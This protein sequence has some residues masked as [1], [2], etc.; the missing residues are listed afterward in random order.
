[1]K[2]LDGHSHMLQ[3][4]APLDKLK[5]KVSEIEGFDMNRLLDRLDDLGVSH[6]Q[7]MYGAV[8]WVQMNS[9]QTY[10][11]VHRKG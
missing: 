6:F 5:K 11:R 1:M 2:I 8:G 9:Q 3:T 7:T 4:T 10:K